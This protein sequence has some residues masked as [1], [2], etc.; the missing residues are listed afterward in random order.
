MQGMWMEQ[1]WFVPPS[2]FLSHMKSE[3]RKH[4]LSISCRKEYRKGEYIF[5]AG[6]PGMNVY[7]LEEGRAKIFQNSVQGREMI[8]WFCLPGEIFGL[9][10]LPRGGKREVYAEACTACTVY[11]VSRNDF[12]NFLLTHP[13]TA[14]QM[15]DLLSCRM[16]VLGHMMLN[17][18]SDDV[19]SRIIKLVLRLAPRYQVENQQ[20]VSLD[21]PLTH[22]EIADMIGASRP[23]VTSVLG[24]L[25]RKGVIHMN[26]HCITVRYCEHLSD[27]ISPETNELLLQQN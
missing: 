13:H 22:Q 17:L 16:R 11:A 24:E 27:A 7:I 3:D 5:Q 15:I 25:R 26:G 6:A 2:D 20:E 4:L 14:L 10:E 9:A 12:Q 18:A 8:L 21:I 19:A 1:F 23:T